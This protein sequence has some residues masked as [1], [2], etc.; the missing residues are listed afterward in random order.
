MGVYQTN[1]SAAKS[2][3]LTS[4]AFAIICWLCVNHLQNVVE[5]TT[6]RYVELKFLK[7]IEVNTEIHIVAIN[8]RLY[9]HHWSLRTSASFYNISNLVCLAGSTKFLK[10]SCWLMMSTFWIKMEKFFLG[11]IPI[12]V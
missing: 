12:L 5:Y 11:F 2:I 9:V 10:V 6:F 4:I 3:A 1:T 7:H 8:V